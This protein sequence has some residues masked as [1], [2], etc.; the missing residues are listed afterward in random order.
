MVQKREFGDYSL[1]VLKSGKTEARVTDLGA[2]LQSLRYAGR[3]TVLGYDTPEAYL[4]GTDFLGASIGRYG[5]RIAGAS[6]PLNGRTVRLI[7]NEGPNQLHGGP[8]SYDKRRWEAE[9]LENG[10]RFTLVS[11]DGDGGF[12]GT[13]TAGVTYTLT[14]DTLRI[15]F[16]GECDQDT[17]YAPTNHSYFDLAGDRDCLK[18]RLWLGA[19]KVVEVGEGLIPTGRLLPAEGAFD[20]SR[21]KPIGQE[22]DH[23]F[24]LTGEHACSLAAGGVRMDLF[25]D[26]PAVQIYTGRYLHAPYGA[27]AGVAIEPE[28]YPDSP[29]QPRFPSTLLKAGEHFHRWAEYRFSAE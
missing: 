14:G 11:P 19:D 3:E 23:C 8:R 15:D 20:F 17:V 4:E 28:F 7:P 2:T 21:E 1:Y 22:F 27:F 12:P 6:F 25:T 16:E 26:L 5:N 13:L 29:N 24:P 9:L 18:A 10:V